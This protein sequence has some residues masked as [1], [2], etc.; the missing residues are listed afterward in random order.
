MN[1]ESTVIT[2]TRLNLADGSFA[3]NF[4]ILSKDLLSATPISGMTQFRK[5]FGWYSS[6]SNFYRQCT[7]QVTSEFFCTCFYKCLIYTA[8]ALNDATTIQQL[9][10][11]NLNQPCTQ[12]FFTTCFNI[13][14][15]KPRTPL[16]LFFTWEAYGILDCFNYGKLVALTTSP[17]VPSTTHSQWMNATWNNNP[18]VAGIKALQTSSCY[19]VKNVDTRIIFDNNCDNSTAC[20]GGAVCTAKVCPL[21]GCVRLANNSNIWS[22]S[23][24]DYWQATPNFRI[25]SAEYTFAA[26]HS[27]IEYAAPRAF[28][29]QHNIFA[30]TTNPNTAG[31]LGES[32]AVEKF[33]SSTCSAMPAAGYT[34]FRRYAFPLQYNND[35]FLNA[36]PSLL[37]TG[38]M[39]NAN[40]TCSSGL[41]SSSGNCLCANDNDCGG[42]NVVCN[43]TLGVCQ[44]LTVA[45]GGTIIVSVCGQDSDCPSGQY[46]DIAGTY[47]CRAPFA[48]GACGRDA[49]CVSTSCSNG[50]CDAPC[51]TYGNTLACGSRNY[52]I[53]TSTDH[54]FDDAATAPRTS[55]IV[56]IV[57]Y[58][59]DFN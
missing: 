18:L 5:C 4:V 21:A 57:L 37:A 38:A 20:P 40:I 31:A 6:N 2:S 47:R 51:F 1:S 30:T 8:I 33:N 23:N 56:R 13:G 42:L 54:N 32:C 49:M 26:Q 22:C 19:L 29:M 7:D 52:T 9:Y 3:V 50:N 16:G 59:Q 46:C 15:S 39:C 41:C 45:T 14:D 27:S 48:S 12:G 11:N 53:Y 58:T 35:I 17:F 25:N 28:Y 43:N 34:L 24:G 36:G 55:P 44:A 10:I